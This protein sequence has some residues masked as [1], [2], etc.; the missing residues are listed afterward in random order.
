MKN[1]LLFTACWSMLMLFALA[2]CSSQ[3]TVKTPSV[4]PSS[5][6]SKPA[7][8]AAP[9]SPLP[10]VFPRQKRLVITYEGEDGKT[11]LELLKAHARVRS[12]TSQLGEL[13]EEINGVANANGYYL[14]YFVN[15]AMV[16][17]G[18]AQYVTKKGD[19]I[20]WKLVGPRKQ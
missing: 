19:K 18:A 16:K 11:A 7:P 4:P 12:A 1:K 14:L 9:A 6:N 10:A 20:E 5:T 13:V 2:A 17:T 15:A 8:T 3:A